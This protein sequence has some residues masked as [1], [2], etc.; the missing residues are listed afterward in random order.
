MLMS[1]YF[2]CQN[3]D[4]EVRTNPFLTPEVGARYPCVDHQLKAAV[5]GRQ[6]RFMTSLKLSVVVQQEQ[7]SDVILKWL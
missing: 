2:P 3:L 4:G 5:V 7:F 6:V 1:V